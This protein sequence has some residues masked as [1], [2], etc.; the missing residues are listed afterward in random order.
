MLSGIGDEEQLRRHGIKAIVHAPE[1]GRNFQDHLLHGGC[2]WEA[3]EAQPHR[4]SAAEASGFWKSQAGFASPDLN[5]VQIEL[6]YTSD[7]IGKEY[8]PPPTS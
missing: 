4:N 2:L 5:L 8:W 6:P 7:V 1:V 3:K